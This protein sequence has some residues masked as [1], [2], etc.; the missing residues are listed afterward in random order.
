MLTNE[1]GTTGH[2][3]KNGHERRQPE[4]KPQN[5]EIVHLEKPDIGKRKLGENS[6]LEDGHKYRANEKNNR[7]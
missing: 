3:L 2:D 5:S 6:R 7:S 4:K 1:N